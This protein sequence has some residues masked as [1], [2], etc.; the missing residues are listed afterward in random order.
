LGYDAR[1]AH[2]QYEGESGEMDSKKDA[3]EGTEAE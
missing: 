2:T 3:E 1:T